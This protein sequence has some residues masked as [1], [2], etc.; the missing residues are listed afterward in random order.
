M[1]SDPRSIQKD[2]DAVKNWTLNLTDW[3]DG[4]TISSATVTADTGLTVDSYSNTGETVTAWLSGG[5]VGQRY[6][7]RFRV[8][9]CMGITDDCSV[10]VIMV[11]Q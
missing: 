5:T 2:P 9:T 3:L 6:N 10:T 1:I 7:L 4:D 11:N 8:I